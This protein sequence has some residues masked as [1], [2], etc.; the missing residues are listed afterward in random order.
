MH[1]LLGDLPPSYIGQIVMTTLPLDPNLGSQE[2]KADE[3][4]PERL[5][6]QAFPRVRCRLLDM[7]E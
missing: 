3:P 7:R 4:D 5:A 6:S 1:Y 2:P